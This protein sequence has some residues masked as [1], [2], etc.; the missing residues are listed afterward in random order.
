MLPPLAL[1][2]SCW[3]SVYETVVW[4]LVGPIAVMSVVNLLILFV[5]VKA[6]FTLKDHV[7]G[8]GNLRT[9]LWLSV[10]SLPLM[11]VMWVLAVLSAS[12][13][14]QLLS[15]LLCVIVL[16]HSVFC[17]IGYCVINKRVRENLHRIGLRCMGKKVPLLDSS[18][19]VSNSSPNANPRSPGGFLAGSYDT[20]R[21]NMGI[22]ASSTTSR[23]TAKTGS[24]PYRSDGQLRHTSTST[25]NYNSTS[26]MQSYMKG[27]E[28]GSK[29]R[30]GGKYKRRK[31]SDSGSESDGRS[32]DLASSHSSDEEESRA[33]GNLSTLQ[34]SNNGQGYLPNIT[35]HVT[36]S[37][38]PELN[39]VQSPQLFPSV[40]APLYAPRW[41]SQLPEA[42]LPSS[43]SANNNLNGN[44]VGRWSQDTCSDNEVHPMHK[45][46]S[47]HPLPN[48]DITDHTYLHHQK[49]NMPPSILEN[50]AESYNYNHPKSTQSPNHLNNN[51]HDMMAGVYDR[52]AY[53]LKKDYPDN[54]NYPEFVQQM[55][56]LSYTGVGGALDGKDFGSTQL[57]NHMRPYQQRGLMGSKTNSP[58][59]SKEH[60]TSELYSPQYS[61]GSGNNNIRSPM[62]YNADPVQSL[63]NDYQVGYYIRLCCE[64]IP[65]LG[66]LIKFCLI[67]E[68]EITSIDTG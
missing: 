37:T 4:W 6:A 15:L 33:G 49:M 46:S 36:A 38:P 39:V 5:S 43:S 50:I 51:T 41:S 19:G 44:N 7:L 48:P 26:D 30:E 61:N 47:P 27:Y 8:F 62:M 2:S 9:L 53:E 3:L 1:I 12:E 35:E 55:T 65:E 68:T 67:S 31:D 23:S 17:M 28:S 11:G 58:Y 14:S 63:K 16:V 52:E 24:S 20:A 60:I 42:Y 66:Q 45:P 59:M 57:V 54:N 64:V 32:L 25:S 40:K 18:M 34:R 13:N 56:S 10:V 29:H 21:R 22:S